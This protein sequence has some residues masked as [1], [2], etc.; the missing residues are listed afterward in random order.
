MYN[1]NFENLNGVV[2]IF[3]KNYSGKSRNGEPVMRSYSASPVSCRKRNCSVSY[4]GAMIAT[5]FSASEFQCETTEAAKERWGHFACAVS[6]INYS[7]SIL[8]S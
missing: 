7:S 3:G 6:Q 2:G 1:I 8:N 5:S 4:A